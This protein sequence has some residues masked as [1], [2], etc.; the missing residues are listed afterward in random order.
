LWKKYDSAY[1]WS[2]Y[3]LSALRRKAEKEN[4]HHVEFSVGGHSYIMDIS[5]QQS[6][7]NVY[8]RRVLMKDGRRV[9]IRELTKYQ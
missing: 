7:K 2:P 6:T 9:T 4:T 8:V 3:D 5:M 1:F